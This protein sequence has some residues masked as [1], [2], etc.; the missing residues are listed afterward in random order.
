M[1]SFASSADSPDN[2]F[3]KLE[4]I[5]KGSFGEVY[6][7]IDKRTN[8]VIAIKVLDLDT[9]DDEITDVRKEIT[10]LM[11]CDSEHVTRYHGSFLNGT[12]LWIIM[13]YA[14]GGSMRNILSSGPIEE[15][16][17]AIIAREVLL[18]LVYLHKSAEIIH[19]DIKA[20]N[21]L[22]THDCKVKLCDFGVAGQITKT[23][24]RRH[25][26]V[27]TP[28]WMAPEIIKRN[29]YDYKADIWSLGITIIELA[30]GN[31]PFADQDRRRAL[32]LIPRTRP[33]RL[34][35]NFSGMLK[36]FIALCLKEEPEERPTAEDLLKSRFILRA[37]KGTSSLQDL[38]DRHEQW[39]RDNPDVGGEIDPLSVAD[40]DE[41]LQTFDEWDFDTMKSL[42]PT[43]R[44]SIIRKPKPGAA[45]GLDILKE[46]DALGTIRPAT[47]SRS[48]GRAT[49]GPV[50]DDY[51]LGPTPAGQRTPTTRRNRPAQPLT[52]NQLEDIE[53][54]LEDL[55]NGQSPVSRKPVETLEESLESLQGLIDEVSTMQKPAAPPQPV[56]PTRSASTKPPVLSPSAMAALG[57]LESQFAFIEYPPSSIVDPQTTPQSETHGLEP[58]E[59]YLGELKHNIPTHVPNRPQPIAPTRSTSNAPVQPSNDGT[60]RSSLSRTHIPSS[61]VDEKTLQHARRAEAD[62]STIKKHERASSYGGTSNL[63]SPTTDDAKSGS[64]M[65]AIRVGLHGLPVGNVPFSPFTPMYGMPRSPGRRYPVPMMPGS[66]L[67]G[68]MGPMRMGAPPW[69]RQRNMSM[70]NVMP[71]KHSLKDPA[72]AA[73]AATGRKPSLQ[74]QAYHPSLVKPLDLAPLSDKEHIQ[75]EMIA[76]ATET[77]RLLESFEKVFAGL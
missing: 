8:Q 73:A 30:T 52:S 38:L 14:A 39:K 74:G 40:E 70:P 3:V 17:I 75:Q 10:L 58:S 46:E 59:S 4:R 27:G 43:R 69:L 12:K 33:A 22:L 67:G 62:T 24:L 53:R 9:D 68:N 21:I 7:G 6:K 50:L 55:L 1:D 47:A 5:G 64:N 2:H 16:H 44:A 56:A 35:G 23:C 51:D 19:R 13:D 28:Y 57:E 54:S 48:L 66:P 45:S 61:S 49:T 36:E 37:A 20:A 11:H 42:D 72:M 26:F 63:T 15:R 41:E 60:T 25:S 32:F 31:P 18:A 34:E 29:Q 76:R 65:N 77:S 71:W